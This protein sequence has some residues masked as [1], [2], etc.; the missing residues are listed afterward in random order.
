LGPFEHQNAVDLQNCR[1]FVAHVNHQTLIH[2]QLCLQQSAH[3]K[4]Q[5]MIVATHEGTHCYF[6]PVAYQN[7]PGVVAN[8]KH[9]AALEDRHTPAGLGVIHNSGSSAY[10][11]KAG[12]GKPRMQAVQV[13]LDFQILLVL[14]EAQSHI[15][16][17]AAGNHTPLVIDGCYTLVHPEKH[18]TVAVEAEGNQLQTVQAKVHQILGAALEEHQNLN[19]IAEMSQTQAADF[20]CL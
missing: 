17:E 10:H 12:F 5:N 3:D 8:E 16:T 6:G 7:L 15:L 1:C 4:L 2:L 20:E 18:Q 14:G 13:V 19:A 9:V 11:V